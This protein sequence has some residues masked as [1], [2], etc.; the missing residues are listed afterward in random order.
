MTTIVVGGGRVGPRFVVIANR[1]CAAA[2]DS[3]TGIGQ[4]LERCVR[5]TYFS[6]AGCGPRDTF[7]EVQFHLFAIKC[8]FV[9]VVMCLLNAKLPVSIAV[10]EVV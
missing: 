3:G 2:A 8:V 7:K 6:Y 10:N 5:Y 1:R 9:D 4:T